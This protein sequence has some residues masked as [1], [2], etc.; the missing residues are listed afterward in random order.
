MCMVHTL[1]YPCSFTEMKKISET[2]EIYTYEIKEVI[3]KLLILIDII[4]SKKLL[5]GSI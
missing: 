1:C 3:A 5:Q 2:I 4:K